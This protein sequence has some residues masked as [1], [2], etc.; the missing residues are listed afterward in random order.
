MESGT[1]S[2]TGPRPEGSPEA[3]GGLPNLIVIG[4]QKCGTSGLH[5]YLGLH[6]DVSVSEPKELNFFIAERNWPRG[7]DWYR[8]RLDQSAAVRV[9]ASPNYTAYPQHRGV[10]E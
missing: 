10:P 5:Y 6:P 1:K 9:D 8:S 4:A 3:A 2:G 7:L